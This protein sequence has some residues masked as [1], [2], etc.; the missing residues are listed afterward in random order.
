MYI[1]NYVR[2]YT[3]NVKKTK[4]MSVSK[5]GD[6]NANIV[7]NEERI[8]QVEQFC[9]MASLITDNG[10]CSKEIRARMAMAKTAFNKREEVLTRGNRMKVK[11][12][13]KTDAWSVLLYGR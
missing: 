4:V 13:I 3:Y 5:Q 7:L 9:C 8:K 11:N 10:S 12:I 1:Y 6:G 2:I